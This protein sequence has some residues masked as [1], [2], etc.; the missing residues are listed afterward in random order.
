MQESAGN[1]VKDTKISSNK[2]NRIKSETEISNPHSVHDTA[3]HN[4]TST[5]GLQNISCSITF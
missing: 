1:E 2:E 5:S 4:N 3:V